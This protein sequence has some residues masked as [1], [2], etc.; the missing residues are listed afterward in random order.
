MFHHDPLADNVV[1]LPFV[2]ARRAASAPALARY[3][4]LLGASPR[5]QEVYQRI[6]RVAPTSATVF[7]SGESRFPPP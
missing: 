4:E 7:L 6:A 2:A 5:M 3:G 1:T